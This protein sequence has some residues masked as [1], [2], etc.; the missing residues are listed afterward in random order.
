MILRLGNLA[1]LAVV[2]AA[3]ADCHGALLNSWEND[4][5]GW[6]ILQGAYATAGYD[7]GVG[8]T[9][10]TY[11]WKIAGGTAGPSYGGFIEGPSTMALTSALAGADQLL[12][13]VTV[14]T[15]GDFGWYLQWT[16]IVD[17]ADTGYTSLDGYTYSQTANIGS[18]SPKTLTWT[19]SSAMRTTLAASSNPTKILFQVGGGSNGGTNNT[20]YLDNLRTTAAIP[21]PTSAVLAGLTALLALAARKHRRA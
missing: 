9:N 18:S 13:D 19:I 10:Q 11:S 2:A 4:A 6:T 12:I 15:G 21:E 8:V 16:A 7:T 1:I 20:M 17:N 14:P 3:A 5:E